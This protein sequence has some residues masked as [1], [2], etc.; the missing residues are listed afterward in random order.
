VRCWPAFV[1]TPTHPRA[2]RAIPRSE[3]GTIHLTVRAAA[4]VRVGTI[5]DFGRSADAANLESRPEI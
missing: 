2:A 5:C 1:F 3:P 4:S